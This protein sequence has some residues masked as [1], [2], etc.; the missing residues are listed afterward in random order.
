MT[1]PPLCSTPTDTLLP[2]TTLF[3][4][5]CVWILGGG[6]VRGRGDR[7]SLGVP[8]CSGDDGLRPL[9]ERQLRVFVGAPGQ[10]GGQAL[11]QFLAA[12]AVIHGRE[13]GRAHV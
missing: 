7:G 9:G 6:Q 11:G 10:D 1:P 5:R 8:V 2:Y 13:I 3:R 12:V 4:S